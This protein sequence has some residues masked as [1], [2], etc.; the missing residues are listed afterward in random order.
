MSVLKIV[1]F[2]NAN[3]EWLGPHCELWVAITG[4]A[5]I[6]LKSSHPELWHV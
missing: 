3:S 2:S 5:H 1:R 6:S 4:Q